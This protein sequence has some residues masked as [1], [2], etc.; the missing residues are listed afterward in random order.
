MSTFHL[1]LSTICLLQ[2]MP[3]PNCA[4]PP[5]VSCGLS[6]HLGS[7]AHGQCWLSGGHSAPSQK[8]QAT[9]PNASSSNPFAFLWL[10]YP[11]CLPG[12]LKSLPHLIP[13]A[14]DAAHGSSQAVG[15]PLS[16]GEIVTVNWRWKG[17][18]HW[19]NWEKGALGK[20]NR[21]SQ[22][23]EVGRCLVSG[24]RRPVLVECKELGEAVEMRLENWQGPNNA[25][26]MLSARET[27]VGVFREVRHDL[28]Y[29]S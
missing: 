18:K 6:H 7:R 1:I 27:I 23:P 15:Q 21:K 4:P 22:G 9:C 29:I 10:S 5:P 2:G 3:C 16:G 24:W 13:S 26:W 20:E 12:L 17:V 8:P 14:A 25:L 28:T 11:A 19:K